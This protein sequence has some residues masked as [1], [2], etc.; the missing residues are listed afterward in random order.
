M[1]NSSLLLFLCDKWNDSY[2]TVKKTAYERVGGQVGILGVSRSQVTKVGLRIR[3]GSHGGDPG[4]AL[5]L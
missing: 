3:A 4:F 2:H 5:A 1:P